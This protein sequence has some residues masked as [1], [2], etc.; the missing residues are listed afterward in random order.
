MISITLFS[1]FHVGKRQKVRY[2]V[3]VRKKYFLTRSLDRQASGFHQASCENS[4]QY[5]GEIQGFAPNI[6]GQKGQETHLIKTLKKC[7]ASVS[8]NIFHGLMLLN[9]TKDL[10]SLFS[11]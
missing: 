4:T 6:T 11:Q 10:Y 5:F 3:K 7:G 1:D 9:L 2:L 8:L